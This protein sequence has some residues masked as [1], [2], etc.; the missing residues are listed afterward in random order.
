MMLLS[1][2]LAESFNTRT[3]TLGLEKIVPPLSEALQRRENCSPGTAVLE[4]L[5]TLIQ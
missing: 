2:S 3:P 1:P 4:H 5:Q